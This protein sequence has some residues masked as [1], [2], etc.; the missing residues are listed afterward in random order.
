MNR[1][2]QA[3]EPS[4]EELLASI[5]LIIAD[6]GKGGSHPKEETAS[7]QADAG[8]TP[9]QTGPQSEGAGDDVFDLTDELVFPEDQAAPPPAPSVQ[10]MPSAPGP[11][12]DAPETA[13]SAPA[14]PG[15]EFPPFARPPAAPGRPANVRPARQESR[16]QTQS[17]GAMPMWSRREMPSAGSN[18]QAPSARQRP[19]SA[20]KPQAANWAEDIQIPVPDQGPVS[21]FGAGA[22]GAQRQEPEAGTEGESIDEA[23][24]VAALAQKL[25]RSAIGAMGSKELKSA[26]EVDFQHLD[27]A[28]K[29]DVSEKLAD[30]I[31]RETA[32]Q[33][34]PQL[35]SLLDE[36]LRHDF[37][38]QAKASE[39][40]TAA[41]EGKPDAAPVMASNAEARQRKDS[42]DV[43]HSA[44][45]AQAAP[46]LTD[47][48]PAPSAAT[49]PAARQPRAQAQYTGSAQT[50]APAQAGLTL[51]G[52]VR[53][54]LRPL[55][56]QWLNENMPRILENAIREEIAVRGVF[57]KQE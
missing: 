22:E 14:A 11:E 1:A 45:A 34:N 3:P 36:V 5:R 41:A 48:G 53:E 4:M 20:A 10:E 23:A 2:D 25:A 15:E 29:A 8:G 13:V 38:R 32:V 12:L 16:T 26:Q 7:A 28:S 50:S 44:P 37:I 47:G 33:G 46:G 31:E 35:P 56:V 40:E 43:Q 27:T 18:Y 30:A 39:P 52:A 6:A 17:P 57:P 51:E 55:L 42:T 21:L 54:M 9:G 19:E 24:A 49:V